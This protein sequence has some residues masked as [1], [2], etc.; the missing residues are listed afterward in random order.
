MGLSQKS[1]HVA[2]EHVFWSPVPSFSAAVSV[3]CQS[4]LHWLCQGSPFVK[5]NKI[6]GAKASRGSVSLRRYQFSWWNMCSCFSRGAQKNA[7]LTIVGHF[8]HIRVVVCGEA[9]V[10]CKSRQ[11]C[12][13]SEEETWTFFFNADFVRRS[14]AGLITHMCDFRQLAF[15]HRKQLTELVDYLPK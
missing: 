14:V 2:S 11:S 8:T 10:K 15:W 3:L 9:H 1:H 4:S 5:R 13:T 12:S 6:L 7:A